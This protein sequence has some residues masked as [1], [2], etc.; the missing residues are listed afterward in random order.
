MKK[1]HIAF[2]IA[3]LGIAVLLLPSRWT[4]YSCFKIFINIYKDSIYSIKHNLDLALL[5]QVTKLLIWNETL[6]IYRYAFKAVDRTL[7][8]LM[9]AVDLLL[10]EKPFGS[11]VIVFRKD[12]C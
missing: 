4:A 2:V 6:M 11:K 8:D 7:K 12:F 1:K 9:K 3:F 10:E 5:L